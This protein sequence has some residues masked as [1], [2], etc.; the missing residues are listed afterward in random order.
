MKNKRTVVITGGHI[1][2]AIAVTDA[3]KDDVSVV[4]IGRKYAMEGSRIPSFEYRLMTK[5][6]IRFIPITTGRLQRHMSWKTIP[7]LVKI[8]VGCIQSLWYCLRERPSLIVSF[9]GYVALPPAIAGWLCRIP[10][11]T[12]EQTLVAGLSNKIIA[13][14]AKRVCVTFPE[15]LTQLPKGKA[16]YTGLPI[17]AALFTPPK[18]SPFALDLTHYPLI[19]ITGG[20]TGARSLNRLLFPILPALLRHHSIVHQVGDTSLTEAQKIRESLPDEY[21][22]RYI[23]QSYILT[24]TLS[25]VLSHAALVVGRSGANTVMELAALGKVALLVPLPWSGG[26]EQQENAAWL[27]RS[28]GAVVLK[29]AELTPQILE[30][31]IETTWAN[32]TSFQ[33]RA[34]A[35]A[36]HIPRDGTKRFV[37]EIEHILRP[38]P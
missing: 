14:I 1:T 36:Q 12:H 7:S 21:K 18:K 33:Q 29:Q 32:L 15:T 11:I 2:P 9:G 6:G 22:D 31:T 19:Y 13:R 27:A 26:G 4:F 28:G 5:R 25:W 20:G 16:V 8:P 24:T 3:L 35:C 23:V 38:T 10:V 17:R 37:R 34:D 30:H